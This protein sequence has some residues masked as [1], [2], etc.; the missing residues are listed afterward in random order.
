MASKLRNLRGGW[1]KLAYGGLALGVG[2]VLLTGVMKMKKRT[3]SAITFSDFS[4]MNTFENIVREGQ[5]ASDQNF[6]LLE[7]FLPF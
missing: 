7:L 3:V 6:P 4:N 2:G 5:Y 1:R